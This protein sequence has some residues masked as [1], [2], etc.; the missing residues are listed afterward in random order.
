MEQLLVLLAARV[1]E[2][3]LNTVH[4][5]TGEPGPRMLDALKELGS[6]YFV[7]DYPITKADGSRLASKLR[8]FQ[9]IL[10]QTHFISLFNPVLRSIKKE[11]GAKRLLVT[12]H[13]GGRVSKKSFVSERLAWLRGRWAATYIDNVV[14]VSDYVCERDIVGAHFPRSKVRRIYN[15]IDTSRFVP[16]T[17]AR[18]NQR[19]TLGFIGRLMSQKGLGTLLEATS[20]L[21]DNGFDFILLIA[22]EGPQAAEFEDQTQR[23]GI[24]DRVSFL[25]QIEDAVAFYHRLDILIVP[26]EID[27]SFGLVAAEGAACGVCVITSDSGGMPEIF[28]S[29][30]NSEL[31]F[32]RGRVDLL[33][34][35]LTDLMCD[36]MYRR[37]LA[38]KARARVVDTFSLDRTVENYAAQ[39]LTLV[40]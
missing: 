3:G 25:G 10:I 13:S 28:D 11:A 32:P 26:S 14:G 23:L 34:K 24:T 4:V 37:E 1:K 5:F 12:D 39:L 18:L 19:L 30:V 33:T 8:E 22:G 16:P 27:E 40:K 7:V 9:P 38:I 21:I 20:K 31:S 17:D 2:D 36:P 29:A 6:P 15:G 35:K